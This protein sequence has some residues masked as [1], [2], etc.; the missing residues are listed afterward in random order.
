V[1]AK[2]RELILHRGKKGLDRFDQVCCVHRWQTSIA[3]RRFVLL[4]VVRVV[5]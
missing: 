5:V 4:I 1:F 2:L 3:A